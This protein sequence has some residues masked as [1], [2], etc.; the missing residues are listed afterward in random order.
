MFGSLKVGDGNGSLRGEGYSTFFVWLLLD[1]L[2]IFFL[3]SLNHK[4]PSFSCY[5]LQLSYSIFVS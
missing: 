3:L 4:M 1:S 2:L 5:S